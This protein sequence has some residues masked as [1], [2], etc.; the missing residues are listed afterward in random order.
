MTEVTCKICGYTWEPRVASPAACPRCKRYDWDLNKD[1]DELKRQAR[2]AAK[3][4]FHYA[5]KRGEV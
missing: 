4:D 1:E 3:E 2:D 5:R